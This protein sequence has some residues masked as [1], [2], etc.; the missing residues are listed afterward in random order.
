M[1]S[2]HLFDG[3]PRPDFTE[4]FLTS[5]GHHLMLAQVDDA[6]VGFISGIEIHH[7][8]KATEMLIYELGVDASHRRQGIGRQLVLALLEV[9]K[10]R[11]CR[12]MWVPLEPQ[13]EHYEAALATY[14][15]AGAT[16]SEPA[17]ICTWSA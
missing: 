8:D 9:S 2:G 6:S 4:T 12:G 11:G 1:A 10:E 7:P 15:S 3:P 13:D 16:D 5:P 14:R 17:T